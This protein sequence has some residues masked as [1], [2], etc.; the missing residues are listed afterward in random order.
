MLRCGSKPT[1]ESGWGSCAAISRGQRFLTN[2][3]RSTAAD[4]RERELKTPWRN[5]AAHAVMSTLQ[6]MQRP[7]ALAPR[8]RQPLANR[9]AVDREWLLLAG[10]VS[11]PA[12]GE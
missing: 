5:G 12:G 1:T 3:C 6:F 11:N 7:A 4:Q 10:C 2:A 9:K 8:P